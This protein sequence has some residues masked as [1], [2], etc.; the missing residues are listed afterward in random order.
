MHGVA[1]AAGD[2]LSR[3]AIGRTMDGL[4]KPITAVDQTP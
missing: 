4:L 1:M 2:S 3:T